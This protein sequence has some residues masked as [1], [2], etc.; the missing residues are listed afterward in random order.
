MTA[1]PTNRQ[2]SLGV[3]VKALSN[4]NMLARRSAL[5]APLALGGCSWF[6]DMFSEKKTILP[7]KRETVI[8]DRRGLVVDDAAAKVVLPPAVR[9]ADWPQAG[10]NPSHLMG[11][12]EANDHLTEAW[13]ADI[14]EGG[15][16]RQVITAQPVV[17]NGSVFTMDSDAV[18]SAFS[19]ADGKRQWTFDTKPK[20]DDSTNVGGGLGADGTTLYAVNGLSQMVALD[21]ATGKEKWRQS[22]GAPARSAPT[23]ADGRVFVILIS[24]QL[25][26]FTAAEGRQLWSFQSSSP[27][28]AMLGQP[29]PAYYRG[30]VVAGFGS[31]ELACLR[32]ETG[33]VVWTDGLGASE[34]RASVADF[35]SIRGLPVIANGLVY[36]ISMGGLLVC[37][38][39]PT[40]RRVWDRQIAGE[41]T[42][43]IAGDW[44]FVISAQQQIAAINITNGRI[45]W[46]TQLPRWE[47][48]EKRKH[49]LTWYGPL[50]VSD[51][52]IVTGTSED[53]L[54]L[55]P[56]TGEILGHISLSQAA[57]PSA[58]VVAGGT[59]LILTNDGRLMALR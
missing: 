26:A 52:L 32:A 29:A 49:T 23:V 57:A 36:A 34:G 2:G 39:V 43:Y 58:P 19:L 40:G 46:I 59:V 28:T 56:Y 54:S 14:G 38:D 5:L 47:D 9:N 37:D 4:K 11:H 10:G 15:G 53:A 13:K 51:R 1:E 18:V 7:G 55:S 3:S 24:D 31:G 22:L 50:L 27:V 45:T 35:L 21:V 44:M 6:D 20:D 33:G 8:T 30:L 16:Y 25:L 17:L 42:A 48:P 12:L 41:D